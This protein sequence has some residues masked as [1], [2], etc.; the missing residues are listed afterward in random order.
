M[1]TTRDSLEMKKLL[2]TIFP[3]DAQAPGIRQSAHLFLWMIFYGVCMAI[4]SLSVEFGLGS[5]E[6][7]SLF[8]AVLLLLGGIVLILLFR[9][10]LNEADDLERTIQTGAL[11]LSS[12]AGFVGTSVYLTLEKTSFVSHVDL[13]HIIVLMALAYSVGLIAGRIRYR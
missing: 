12:G 1:S 7:A 4:P 8:T 11:A 6:T 5:L 9:R 3:I 2:N 10:F 13:T